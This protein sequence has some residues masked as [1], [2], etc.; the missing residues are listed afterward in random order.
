MLAESARIEAERFRRLSEE[1]REIREQHREALEAIRQERESVNPAHRNSTGVPGFTSRE[2]QCAQVN[3][4]P[5]PWR[6]I[7]VGSVAR[8]GEPGTTN[9]L[10]CA[11]EDRSA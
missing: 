2:G 3:S 5:L 4:G 9:R 8:F 10:T 1:A 7:V 6:S 11:R